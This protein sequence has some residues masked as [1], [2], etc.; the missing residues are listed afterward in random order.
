MSFI[1]TKGNMKTKEKNPTAFRRRTI[2]N[3]LFQSR[4]FGVLTTIDVLGIGSGKVRIAREV[5][6]ER[7]IFSD[8]FGPM[9]LGQV[10]TTLRGIL[11]GLAAAYA[12]QISSMVAPQFA[13]ANVD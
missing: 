11:F 2:E 4:R 6:D 10:E 7:A 8:D 3:L 5:T 13:E 12:E 9:N 1:P